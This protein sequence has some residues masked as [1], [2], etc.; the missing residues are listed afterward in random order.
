M[1]RMM[2]AVWLGAVVATSA[3]TRRYAEIEVRNPGLVAVSTMGPHGVQP[4]LP[5]DGSE[6]TAPLP[7]GG[8]VAARRG[9][10]V[11]IAFQERAPLALIDDHNALPRQAPDAGISVNGR[12]LT[13][14]YNVSQARIWPA[15]AVRNDTTPLMLTTDMSNVVDARE[16]KEMRRWPA[17]VCLPV[18]ILFAVLGTG[19]LAAGT[20]TEMRTAGAVYLGAS[21]P[22]LGYAIY[23]LTSSNEIKP[24]ALPGLQQ[25]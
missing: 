13:S 22:L 6:R 14:T 9:S 16:V 20:D 12:T 10:E 17:Y 19:F 5:P 23:N 8:A 1:R 24:L 11:V 15:P 21:A 2:A 7:Y 3:C 25:P 4:L 18:G